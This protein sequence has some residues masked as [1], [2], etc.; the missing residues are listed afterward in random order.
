MPKSFV[1]PIRKYVILRYFSNLGRKNIERK[2]SESLENIILYNVL[3][4]VM[5]NY[6][7]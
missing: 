3:G 6:L 4:C 2:S 5:E 7:G 1:K